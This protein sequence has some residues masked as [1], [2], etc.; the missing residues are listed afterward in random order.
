MKKVLLLGLTLVLGLAVVSQAQVRVKGNF[1]PTKYS[2]QNAISVDP[3]ST[4]QGS[5]VVTPVPNK[6]KS[7]NVVNIVTL[8]TAANALGWGYASATYDHLWADND[9]K[10]ICQI[11]RMGPGSTH[12][13]FSGYIAFDHAQNYGATAS[14]WSLGYQI[15]A[16]VLN[17]GGTYYAD[18]GRYP[19]GGLYNPGGSTDPTNSYFTYFIPNL[20]YTGSGTW[21]GYS[22]GR[23]HWGTQSDTTKRMDWYNPPPSRYGIPEGFTITPLG[24]SFVIDRG[25]DATTTVFD[26]TLFLETGTWNAAT[27]DFDYVAS[28]LPMVGN[29]GCTPTTA[30]VSAD[31]SGNDVWICSIGNNGEASPVFDSTYYPVFFHSADGGNTWGAPIAV[32]LDGT[33]GFDAVKNYISDSRLAQIYTTVPPRDQIAYTTVWDCDLTVDVWRNPHLLVGITLNLGS[34]FSVYVPDGTNTNLDSTYAMFDIYST[35]RGGTWCARVV[36]FNKHFNC[37]TTSSGSAA[38]LYSR[39]GISRSHD[40]TK[41]FYTWDDSWGSS[42]T[43]NSAPDVF[44]RG[45]D[46]ETNMLTNNNGQ[47]AGT[48]VTFLSNVTGTAFAG[49]QAQEVFTIGSGASTKWQIPIVTEGVVSLVLDN[50]VTFYYVSDFSFTQSNFTI[51]GN[52]PSW[53]NTCVPAFPTGISNQAA[54]TLTATV[55]P[56]PVKGVAN[57]KITVPQKGNVTIQLTNLVGQTVM[58]LSRNIETTETFNLDATQ[59]TSGVYFYTVKQGTQKVTGKMIVE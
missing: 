26:G 9:L 31:P 57:M 42:V 8:G 25:Y 51:A 14:D 53:G 47:D 37:P 18:A 21:G 44:A 22:Y 28:T 41:I 36:G 23:S 24:K 6:T 2:N 19:Q 54:S 48:N 5:T 10:A 56:N 16:A 13:S 3:V 43:D 15:Y 17:N 59:L 32:T 40:G 4:S 46:L 52:G 39:P 29:L 45:W 50:A 7:A 38:P 12:P 34:G 33:A 20:S 35:D 11:H 58:S 55:Y 49:D 27:N 1:T 30:K